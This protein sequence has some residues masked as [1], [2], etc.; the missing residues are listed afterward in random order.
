MVAALPDRPRNPD[1]MQAYAQLFS[2][3]IH[4][5]ERRRHGR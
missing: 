4:A 1:L 3:P 2:N 5:A